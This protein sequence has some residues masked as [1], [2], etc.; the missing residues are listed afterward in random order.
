VKGKVTVELAMGPMS[1]MKQVIN[2]KAVTLFNK[3][4][5]WI[6]LEISRNEKKYRFFEETTLVSKAG[7]TLDGIETINGK[8]LM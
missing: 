3:D 6:L 2:E 1:I 4:S 5:A 7:V 8:R